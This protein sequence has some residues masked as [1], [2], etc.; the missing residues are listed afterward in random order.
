MNALG[1]SKKTMSSFVPYG[2]L[3]KKQT[4]MQEFVGI[5]GYL[6]ITRP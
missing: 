6:E 1:V 5:L 3:V 4:T 2:S